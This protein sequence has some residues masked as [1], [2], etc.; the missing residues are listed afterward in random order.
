MT[1]CLCTAVL[2][3]QRSYSE[4][5]LKVSLIS[6]SPVLVSLII[7]YS[8]EELSMVFLHF[9]GPEQSGNSLAA[10]VPTPWPLPHHGCRA[11]LQ[12]VSGKAVLSF[13]VAIFFKHSLANL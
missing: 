11:R 6:A 4:H 1:F 12:N 8:K 9:L 10:K 7:S 2:L 5:K 13:L 3:F